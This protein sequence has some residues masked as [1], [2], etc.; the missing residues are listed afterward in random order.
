[1]LPVSTFFLVVVSPASPTHA[2]Y[3]TLFQ[4]APEPVIASLECFS[5]PFISGSVSALLVGGAGVF[6]VAGTRSWVAA[7]LVTVAWEC[8]A[9]GRFGVGI[10][11]RRVRR[12]D[13]DS[14]SVRR[15]ALWGWLMLYRC[16]SVGLRLCMYMVE[17]EMLS[18]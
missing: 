13:D 8:G 5:T 11:Q 3:D 6:G 15:W 4:P 7:R 9:G 18:L 10:T 12:R 17:N 14:T 1:M 16:G 2:Y